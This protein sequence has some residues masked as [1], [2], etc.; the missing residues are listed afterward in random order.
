MGRALHI[1]PHLA[2]T[3]IACLSLAGATAYTLLAIPKRL[4]PGD[5]QWMAVGASWATAFVAQCGAFLAFIFPVAAHA[6]SG[7]WSW[8]VRVFAAVSVY[9][10]GSMGMLAV[11]AYEDAEHASGHVRTPAEFLEG[12]VTLAAVILLYLLL[13][14]STLMWIATRGQRFRLGQSKRSN[15]MAEQDDHSAA[16]PPQ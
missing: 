16:P 13:A 3:V 1:H 6:L 9:F 15:Q 12:A 2:L 7:R 10:A 8:S 5:P 4:A 11:N 14:L